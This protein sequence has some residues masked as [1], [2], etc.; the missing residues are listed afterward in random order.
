MTLPI[1]DPAIVASLRNLKLLARL[2][3]VF[4]TTLP[5]HLASLQAAVVAGDRPAQRMV[6]HLLRGSASQLGALAL[7]HA[8]TTIEDAIVQDDGRPWPTPAELDALIEA[9]T[10]AMSHAAQTTDR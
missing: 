6:A 5:G 8:F 1:L 10:T 4:V 3:P 7:A 9:T 2:Y